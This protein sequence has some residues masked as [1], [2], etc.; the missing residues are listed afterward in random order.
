MFV[1][2]KAFAP[3]LTCESGGN[4]FQYK[5]GKWNEEPEANAVRNG[6]HCA[7]DPL[8]CLSY[9]PQW[10]GSVYYAVLVDGDIDED[11]SDSKISCTRMKLLKRLSK[12]EFIGF[13]MKYISE[14]PHVCRVKSPKFGEDQTSWNSNGMKIVRGKN[15][16]V[17]GR[18]GEIIGIAKEF[19]D[20]ADIEEITIIKIDGKD[21]LENVD[22]CVECTPFIGGVNL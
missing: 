6:F 17:S 16:R 21:F 19:V 13:A 5:L 4:K 8:D 10:E 12:E 15:P 18:I 1:A 20:S 22:Y 9:Y 3:D 7:G 11:G 2:F 14:H